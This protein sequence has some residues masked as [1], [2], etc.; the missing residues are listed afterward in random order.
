VSQEKRR[1]PILGPLEPHAITVAAERAALPALKNGPR[2]QRVPTTAA[3]ARAWLA[4]TIDRIAIETPPQEPVACAE[5]CAFCCHLKVIA[6][7]V[8]VLA[9]AAQLRR[10]LPTE[11]L[12]EVKARV[13]AAD[14]AFH[15][16]TTDERVLMKAPCPLLEDRRCIGYEARPLHCMG[17][18]SLDAK[19]CERAFEQPDRDLPVP[20]W[21][22]QANAAD[23][24]AAGLSRATVGA[25]L[26]GTMVE[27]VAA[28]RI[29]L[30]APDAEDRWRK[31][32]PV[33]AP[34][35]DAELAAM[36]AASMKR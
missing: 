13:A 24:I 17:A 2:E 25:K 12:A 11:K 3:L 31:G 23:A 14:A 1:L 27:L 33:F 20:V 6:S 7:P 22:P 15:G 5:G 4:D 21:T 32:E 8:E 26:D 34:A 16:K 28:L 10:S 36:I 19:A 9:L 35:Y 30:E 18:V 29:A